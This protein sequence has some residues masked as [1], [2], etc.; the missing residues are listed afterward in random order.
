MTRPDRSPVREAYIAIVV[1]KNL[2][3]VNL[4]PLDPPHDF[5]VSPC[6]SVSVLAAHSRVCTSVHTRGPDLIGVRIGGQT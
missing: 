6:A 2:L 1:R 4:R 5:G 3:G